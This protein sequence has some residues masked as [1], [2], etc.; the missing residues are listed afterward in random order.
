[1]AHGKL[2]ICTTPRANHKLRSIGRNM[3]KNK[4]KP[5]AI[6][7]KKTAKWRE[8]GITIFAIICLGATLVWIIMLAHNSTPSSTGHRHRNDLPESEVLLEPGKI[9][10]STDAFMGHTQMMVPNL[11]GTYY[12]CSQHCIT[13][14]QL[15]EA[16]RFATDPF[17]KKR[18]SKAA[19]FICLHPDKSGK[20][21]Y[22]ESK[23]NH[24]AFIK[25]YMQ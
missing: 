25:T 5:K 9:C 23:E 22:F 17:S 19:A 15:N 4:V 24:Q 14:L 12:A 16:E 7:Q 8:W 1:M 20:V 10:M 2:C 6:L 11:E 18:I 13:A 3:K 21:C